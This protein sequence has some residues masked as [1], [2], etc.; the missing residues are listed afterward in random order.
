MKN[1]NSKILAIV[2]LALLLPMAFMAGMVLANS[3]QTELTLTADSISSWISAIATA[4]IAVLTFILAKETWYL[5]AAQNQQ[6][7]EMQ[8]ESIR[9]HIDLSLTHSIVGIHFIELKIANYGRGI[10]KNIKFKIINQHRNNNEPTK[11]PIINS[12]L[13]LGA[14]SNGISHLGI[15]QV[16]KT[17]VFSFLDVLS[18]IGEEAVFSTK[19]S[20][21]ISYTDMQ[22]TPYKDIILI[23]MSSFRG[24]I[25]IGGGSPNYK[26][27]TNIE[28]IAKWVE[29]L[30][31]GNNGRIDVNSFTDEDRQRERQTLEEHIFK[32]NE[33]NQ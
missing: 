12:I 25:E 2:I 30:T 10:A 8:R 24:V 22:D 28:K 23:D 21:E 4:A 17:F 7:A 20:I 26:I 11:N 13:G 1:E 19:F 14:I 5:R 29:S 9:P 33:K 15:E 18:K 16:Y 6:I 27:A 31:R 3:L 32:Q